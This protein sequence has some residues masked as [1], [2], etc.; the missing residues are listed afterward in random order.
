MEEFP[1]KKNIYKNVMVIAAIFKILLEK[2]SQI[3]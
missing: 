3:C 2:E 1:N